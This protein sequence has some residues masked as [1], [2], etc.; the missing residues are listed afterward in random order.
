MNK[1]MWSRNTQTY[2]QDYQIEEKYRDI[3]RF[4]LFLKNVLVL[5][6]WVPSTIQSGCTKDKFKVERDWKYMVEDKTFHER[7]LI[8]INDL[9]VLNLYWERYATILR[10]LSNIGNT[11]NTCNSFVWYILLQ[12]SYR[13]YILPGKRLISLTL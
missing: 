13:S 9:Y 11:V 7:S 10:V 12:T 1:N 3:L 5:L 6:P 8:S 2:I 4:M